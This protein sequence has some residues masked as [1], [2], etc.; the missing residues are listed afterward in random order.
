MLSPRVRLTR[1]P[2]GYEGGIDLYGC[3]EGSPVGM[4]DGGE[5]WYQSPW[6]WLIPPV[7]LG[8]AIGNAI[9]SYEEACYDATSAQAAQRDWMQR[10]ANPN[11]KPW[12]VPSQDFCPEVRQA[13]GQSE[14]ASQKAA[15]LPGTSIG[16][17]LPVPD[18]V[19]AN[20]AAKAAVYGIDHLAKGANH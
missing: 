20:N 18:I 8:F 7:G 9:G 15:Q 17:P 4:V 14:K 10:A 2:I 12:Q 19:P 1:D 5:A 3:V 11:S 13:Y 6:W 16:G